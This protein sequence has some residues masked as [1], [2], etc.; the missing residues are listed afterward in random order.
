MDEPRRRTA[1][2]LGALRTSA[3]VGMTPTTGDVMKLVLA[4]QPD[5]RSPQDTL[6]A[7]AHAAALAPVAR[8]TPL[9]VDEL[10]GSPAAGLVQDAADMCRRTGADGVH[11][12][13]VLATGVH[14]AVAPEALRELGVTLSEIRKEWRASIARTGKDKAAGWDTVLLDEPERDPPESL[15]RARAFIPTA[16]RPTISSGTGCTRTRSQSSS[17]TATRLRRW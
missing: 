15:P 8:A 9:A 13:H 4:H 10:M 2:L 17:A 14:P 11:L 1:A 3:A 5:R 16:G 7:A 12:R 6:D